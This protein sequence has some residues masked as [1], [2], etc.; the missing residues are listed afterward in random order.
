VST[1]TQAHDWRARLGLPA[2]I[3]LFPLAVMALLFFFDEFDTAAFGV[4]APDIEHAFHLT[5]ARFAL[6]VIL[7]LSLV[8]V[9]ALAVGWMGDRM[10]R[11]R[12]VVAGGVLAG[13]FSFLTGA[14]GTVALLFLVRIG[15]GVGR[16]VNEP[17]HSSL[18]ADYYPP[19]SRGPVYAVHR[20]APQWGHVV[21]AAVTGAVAALAGWRVAF[22]IL[23]VP[24]AVTAV[25]AMRLREPRRGGTDD[26]E[27]A[28]EAEAEDPIAFTEGLRS[29]WS[30]A[31]LRRQY[32]ATMFVGAGVIP[33]AYLLPLY[34]KRVYGLGPFPRGLIVA[35][36]GVAQLVGLAVAGRKTAAWQRISVG[37]PLRRAGFVLAGVGVGIVATAVAPDLAVAIVLTLAANL[38][39]GLFYPPFLAVQALV[40]PARARTLSFG[41][42][43]LFLVLG[44]WVLFVI[45]GVVRVSDDHGTRWGLAVLAPYWLV[46]GLMLASAAGSA[47]KDAAAALR[48]LAAAVASRRERLT[49]GARSLLVC[50]G[51]DVAYDAVQVLFGVDVT[52]AEGE[53]VALL[54]TNGAGKSTLL[55]AVSGLVEPS[56]GSVL[57]DG[58]DITHMDPRGRLDLGI[59]QMP[60]GRS[61]FPTLTDDEC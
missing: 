15:N 1:A 43:A 14:V 20:S 42:A 58:V 23:V 55:K 19:D 24:I 57:F 2:G 60:G 50:T 21:G 38:V 54:G 39:F 49:A 7:N 51:V 6:L 37:E 10:S 35:A 61:V 52:V 26:A 45:P 16:L 36:N 25:A 47:G 22:M 41:V 59:V 34:F 4:L 12:L 46:G 48:S 3:V 32:W 17:V 28:V 29:L 8:L 11:T 18:L 56:S 31:T 40:S 30:V 53:L 33:L 13:A 27:A 9:L 44:V 5:D